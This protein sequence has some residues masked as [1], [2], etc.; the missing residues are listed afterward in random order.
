[1]KLIKA[2]RAITKATM[3]ISKK[4]PLI[5][6]VVGIAGV[7]ATAYFAYKSAKKV[8]VIVESIEAAGRFRHRRHPGRMRPRPAS[9]RRGARG[10]VGRRPRPLTPV[11]GPSG[12]MLLGKKHRA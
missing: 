5:L 10:R 4:S 9:R 11:G 12:P 2:R 7:G 6:T 1:M 8:E 3:A